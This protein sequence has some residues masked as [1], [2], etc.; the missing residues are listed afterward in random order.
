MQATRQMSFVACVSNQPGRRDWLTTVALLIVS[1]SKAYMNKQREKLHCSSAWC[2]FGM[3]HPSLDMQGGEK[4]RAKTKRA[5]VSK[6]FRGLTKTNCGTLLGIVGCSGFA[7]YCSKKT[8][9]RTV[10]RDFLQPRFTKSYWPPRR[11][12]EPRTLALKRN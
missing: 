10:L 1:L 11:Q 12:H 3:H 4:K 7:I 9:L 6:L 5:I 2:S 8:V